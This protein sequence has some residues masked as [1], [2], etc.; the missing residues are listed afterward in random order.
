MNE[1]VKLLKNPWVLLVL[2]ALIIYALWR[3]K[4]GGLINSFT[5]APLPGGSSGLTDQ[6]KQLVR[7]ITNQLF[8]DMDGW[9][10]SM[11]TATWNEFMALDD[12]LFT[13]V[14][15]DYGQR[16]YSQS[17]G[18]TLAQAI[19][20]ENFWITNPLTGSYTKNQFMQRFNA[21]NLI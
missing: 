7:R 5:Q 12:R 15:N 8:H 19:Q 11:D 16:F 21:L 9:G 20:A 6:E 3:W 2:A 17:G 10:I 4:G 14:F 18:K 13:A 1:V